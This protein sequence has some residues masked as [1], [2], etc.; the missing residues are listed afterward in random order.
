MKPAKP[1]G[2]LP[3]LPLRDMVVFP[4]S[5]VKVY[6]GRAASV[7]AVHRAIETDNLIL[8]A[9]QKKA[10]IDTPKRHDLYETGTIGKILRLQGL[11]DGT[12]RL[13]MQGTNACKL[14][15]VVEANDCLEGSYRL[16]DTPPADPAQLKELFKLLLLR[17]R[18]YAQMRQHKESLLE[19]INN[20]AAE[21]YNLFD[22]AAN[23]L[24]LSLEDKY[25]LLACEDVE[26]MVAL[27][28]GH[29]D[30]YLEL[31][32]IDERLQDKVRGQINRNQRE[33]YLN[34]QMKALQQELGE[35]DGGKGDPNEALAARIAATPMTEEANKKAEDELTKLRHMPP[36]SSES[37]VIRNYLDT[38]LNLP[39]KKRT[40][41]NYQLD[42][43]RS[44]LD[45]DHYGL[46][47]V[48]DR[49]VEYIAAYKRSK[50]KIKPPILC[51]V[52]PPGV[53]KTS[54]AK[55][56][57]EAVNRK[58]VRMALGGMR[59]ESEIRGHRRTYI[60][61]M[62]GR[63]MQ[64]LTKAAVTNPV[65][66]FDE[67]D[68]M[69]MDFRGD[70][71]SAL[72]EVLDPEQ[73]N[74][75]NDHYLEV[76]YDLSGVMFICTS[77]SMNIPQALSDRLE[78]IRLAGYTENEKLHIA[79]QF[80][81]ANQ[82]AAH[83]CTKEEVTLGD[84]A[85]KSI[86]NHYTR[87]AGVRSLEREIAKVIRKSLLQ[88]EQ[89]EQQQKSKDRKKHK[90]GKPTPITQIQV[91]SDN[92]ADYLGPRRFEDSELAEADKI[93]V[94]NGLAWTKYGGHMLKVE[95]AVFP[96]KGEC[97]ITGSVGEVMRESVRA[98]QTML[99]ARSH[100]LGLPDNFFNKHDFHVHIPEGA[101]PKDGPSAGI[102]LC[103]ALF[104]LVSGLKVVPQ[105]AMTGELTISGTVLPIG[106]LKEKLL[107]AHRAGVSKVFIPA[108]N[109]KDL[110]EIP[111]EVLDA[112]KVVTVSDIDQLLSQVI[113]GFKPG[114]LTLPQPYLFSK[115]LVEKTQTH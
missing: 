90:G 80:L 13:V 63:I 53:G 71:A 114:W 44:V 111:A 62:P 64:K 70:P 28:I 78:I 54:L 25:K 84:D 38:L 74:R 3:L 109:A 93:G 113:D 59:D 14:G 43:A 29:F 5:V 106:G 69:G 36:M 1:D 67:I 68:K 4:K 10:D 21:P 57:A 91:S 105:I 37:A 92:L 41:P 112:L 11:P 110:V 61:S 47:D 94:V 27:L 79:R 7:R 77:N 60:G 55:S 52:G 99:R 16:I 39:W 100:W 83:S 65:F 82:L 96:G 104:S 87:E 42:H 48:K 102:T 108:K 12:A 17:S 6:V 103:V 58:F 75:F 46:S 18:E 66:L 33:Y 22:F 24:P 15:E 86:I 72:L 115:E 23:M 97:T 32:K 51:L 89:T 88:L 95:T 26:H 20:L 2:R 50:G 98:A 56:I 45:R 85:I 101:T 35:I 73:N 81:L 34:E 40:R 9:T 76:D 8:I 31:H 30:S 49:I 19:A 107:A